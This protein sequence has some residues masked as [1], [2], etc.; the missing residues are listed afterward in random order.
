MSD[1][2]FVIKHIIINIIDFIVIH[3][4]RLIYSNFKLFF[5][6]Y[7]FWG[8]KVQ[9]NKII[10]VNEYYNCN[11]KS[12]AE[13]LLKQKLPY[14]LI[15]LSDYKISDIPSIIKKS[16][17]SDI[18]GAYHLSTAK[19]IIFNSKGDKIRFIKKKSQFVIQTCHGSFPLKFVEAECADKLP[20]E[21]VMNSMADSKMT[22][23]VLSDGRWTSEFIRKALWYKG[24]ILEN[25]YPRNDIYFNANDKYKDIIRN[26]LGI[27]NRKVVIYAPTFRDNGDMSCYGLDGKRLLSNLVK[28]TGDDWCLLVRS[29]PNLW[30]KRLPLEFDENIIDVS[31]YPD[32]QQLFLV[33][34][35]L[36]TDYSSIMID[37]ILM[38]RPVFIFATDENSYVKQRGIRPEFYRLPFLHST[39]NEELFMNMEKV[40]FSNPYS[41]DF[42]QFYGS[43]DSGNAS[44]SVVNRILKEAPV[45]R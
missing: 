34:D 33:S 7:L 35:I 10:F 13:E 20:K 15:W 18:E 23:L 24:E 40:D 29:H 2:L 17:K 11:P 28:R 8:M 5:Y 16:R 43:V 4:R 6:K 19:I 37:F 3:Y 41:D 22:D 27:A 32:A 21:Y 44:E 36:I 31:L 26:K 1:K 39:D 38:H 25:G 30:G 42:M 9:K 45:D 12:I 14:K